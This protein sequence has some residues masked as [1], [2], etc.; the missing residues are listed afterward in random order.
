MRGMSL[1]EEYVDATRDLHIKLTEMPAPPFQEGRRAQL[2]MQVMQQ[3]DLDSVWMDGV[4]NVLGLRKGTV[5]AKTV[6]LDAHLDTVFPEGTDVRVRMHGDTLYAPGIGD[7]TRGLA[8]LIAVLRV[9]N[10]A[11]IHTSD[12]VLFVASVGEEGL[13]DLRGVKHIFSEGPQIDSWISID[14]GGR[15]SVVTQGLGSYRYRIIFK[16]SGGHSWG[17]FGLANP[18]HA[19]GE[20]IHLFVQKAN[21]FTT[22]GD[23]TSYNIGVISGGTS[24]NSI[25]FESSMEID[26]RSVN[27]LRLDSLGGLLEESVYEALEIQN[28]MRRIGAPLTVE[29]VQIGNRPSGELPRALP[30]IQRALA[31]TA[32]MGKRPV[33]RRGSTNANIPIAMGIPA[34]TIGRGGIG[35]NAHALNEWWLDRDAYKATQG[36]FLL[37]LAQSGISG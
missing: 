10:D 26:I 37:L 9:L 18:H 11:D 8:M 29:F 23:R 25:P 3:Y 1:I 17:A 31:T 4:G 5:G 21:R 35:G 16:G 14:G 12:N 27:P 6:C 2:F 20:A 30:L 32:Y 33:I 34:V 36:A 22:S 28:K 15:A 13:G 24:V 7:D 19:L